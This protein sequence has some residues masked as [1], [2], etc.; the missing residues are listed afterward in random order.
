MRAACAG[1][2]LRLRVRRVR[3]ELDGGLDVK[4]FTR[5]PESGASVPLEGYYGTLNPKP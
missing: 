1:L 4:S 2:E 3:E 5:A